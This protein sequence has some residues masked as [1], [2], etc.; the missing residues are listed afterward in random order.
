MQDS[1]IDTILGDDIVFRGKLSF[2]DSLKINGTFKGKI[3]TSGHLVV[4]ASAD[5]DADIEAKTV[6]VEGR[7]RGNVNA[8]AR[9]DIT[10]TA[11]LTGD[12]KTPDLQIESGSHFSGNCIMG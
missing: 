7:L 4:G 3:D 6:S 5:V 11:R 12:I 10:R 2:K 8:A 1:E 9:I